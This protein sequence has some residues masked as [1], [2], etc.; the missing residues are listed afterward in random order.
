MPDQSFVDVILSKLQHDVQRHDKYG[1]CVSEPGRLLVDVPAPSDAKSVAP[2]LKKKL[3]FLTL[4]G[5]EYADVAATF[6]RKPDFKLLS[7]AKA[8]LPFLYSQ[9]VQDLVRQDQEQFLAAACAKVPKLKDA[10]RLIN[11]WLERNQSELTEGPLPALGVHLALANACATE[12]KMWAKA[13]V[14]QLFKRALKWLVNSTLDVQVCHVGGEYSAS[15]RFSLGGAQGEMTKTYQKATKRCEQLKTKSLIPA[16]DADAAPTGPPT[17]PSHRQVPRR[18]LPGRVPHLPRVAR[19]VQ[20]GAQRAAEL[21]PPAPS[22]GR[23]G[24]GLPRGRGVLAHAP[25]GER[26]LPV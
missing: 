9:L 8:K 13:T 22:P 7:P 16:A 10:F 11:F 1:S 2:Y 15:C 25:R 6:P 18:R 5:L 24:F 20:R 23:Q 14:L 12:E 4:A 17:N 3:E 19:R 26:G 21:V